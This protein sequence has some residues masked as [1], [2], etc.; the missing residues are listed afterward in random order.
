MFRVK[1]M[2]HKFQKNLFG[3]LGFLLKVQITI[4]KFFSKL[5]SILSKIW[6]KKFYTSL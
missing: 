4:I 6:N 5:R 2:C 1:Q 3:I